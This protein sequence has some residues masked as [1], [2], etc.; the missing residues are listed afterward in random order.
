MSDTPGLAGKVVVVTGAASGIGR[1]LA[2]AVAARGARPAISDVDEAG[3]EETALLVAGV[4]GRRPHA[5]RL[6][7]RDR[8]GWQRYADAVLA[9]HGGVD[10]VVNNAGIALTADV[11]AMRHDL[12]EQV[13]DVDFWGVVHGTTTFLPHLVAGGGGAVVNVSSVFGLMAVPSQ[14]AY[15]AAK[16]AVRGFTEALRQEMLLAGHP[17]TVSCVH[18]GGI[19]TS[20]VRNA[21]TVGVDHQAQA[22]FFDEALARTSPEEAAQVILDGM[23]AGRA[24]ILVGTDAKVLDK[25]VRLTGAG[26]QRLVVRAVARNRS[27]L[28][29]TTRTAPRGRR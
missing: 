28:L 12:V 11:L 21:T 15:S 20:I 13:M 26:Y 18:P 10:V 23:L 27:R 1:A 14:S 29:P 24:R 8:E 6:D 19:R 25:V 22:A 7:V 4:S 17:V 9:E 5:Q 3:L 2:L 16:F